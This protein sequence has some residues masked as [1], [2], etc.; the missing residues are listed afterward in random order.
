MYTETGAFSTQSLR[1]LFKDAI[2]RGKSKLH[3]YMFREFIFC[4]HISHEN[5]ENYGK[6]GNLGNLYLMKEK[7]EKH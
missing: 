6:L 2:A 7:E 4:N 3:Q 1:T 5:E